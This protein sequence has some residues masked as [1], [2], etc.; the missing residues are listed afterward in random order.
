MKVYGRIFSRRMSERQGRGRVLRK[1]LVSRSKEMK[2]EPKVIKRKLPKIKK[3][4]GT[5]LNQGN[6]QGED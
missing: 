3:G 6:R 5:K 1:V 4:R 2:K